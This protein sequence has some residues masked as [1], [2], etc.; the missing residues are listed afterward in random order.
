MIKQ[1][2]KK[3]TDLA[4]AFHAKPNVMSYSLKAAVKNCDVMPPA[5]RC[6]IS[7]LPVPFAFCIFG[8]FGAL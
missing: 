8:G 1:A 5:D 6:S 7:L 2:E 4:E 3:R